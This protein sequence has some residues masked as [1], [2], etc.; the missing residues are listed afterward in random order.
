MTNY[1]NQLLSEKVKTA[2]K[3]AYDYYKELG[4]EAA[5]EQIK[6]NWIVSSYDENFYSIGPMGDARFNLPGT[7]LNL[8]INFYSDTIQYKDDGRVVVSNIIK[9]GDTEVITASYNGF[10]FSIEINSLKDE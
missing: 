8:S 1:I 3:E 9:Y 4:Y 2:L 10:G 7:K 6:S 5:T